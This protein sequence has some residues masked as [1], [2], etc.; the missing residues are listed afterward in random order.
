M[1][2]LVSKS[3]VAICNYNEHLRVDSNAYNISV[4]MLHWIIIDNSTLIVWTQISYNERRFVH[5]WK[6]YSK[7]LRSRW[8]VIYFIIHFM[9]NLIAQQ[10]IIEVVQKV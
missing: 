6:C 9:V 5:L 8:H 7:Y 1:D 10:L 3:V 4:I 2:V